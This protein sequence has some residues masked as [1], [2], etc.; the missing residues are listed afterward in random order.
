MLKQRKAKKKK[1]LHINVTV[2][3]MKLL[4]RLCR[5]RRGNLEKG[6]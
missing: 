1:V 5:E 6:H 3:T 2:A 4:R